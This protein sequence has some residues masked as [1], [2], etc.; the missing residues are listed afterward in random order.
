MMP[1]E[2]AA[3][4]G[5]IVLRVAEVVALIALAL[6]GADWWVRARVQQGIAQYHQQIIV[7]AFQPRTPPPQPGK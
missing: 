3:R 7:P 5:R 4:V 1:W 6:L 2:Q